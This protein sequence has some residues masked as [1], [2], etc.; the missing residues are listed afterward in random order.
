MSL[1]R[2]ISWQ[3]RSF[4]ILG[5]APGC[6]VRSVGRALGFHHCVLG[7]IH[8]VGMLPGYCRQFGQGSLPRVWYIFWVPSPIESILFHPETEH[9]G[10]APVQAV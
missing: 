5:I 7:S 4:S 1:V 3:T 9:T 6:L 8:D 2:S 10:A